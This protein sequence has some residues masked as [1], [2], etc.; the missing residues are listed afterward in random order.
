MSIDSI[1]ITEPSDIQISLNSLQNIDCFNP[2]GN[3]EI[4]VQGGVLPY[5]YSLNGLDFNQ[6]NLANQLVT[7]SQFN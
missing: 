4:E 1:Q 2:T 3:V 7:T 6:I 5:T